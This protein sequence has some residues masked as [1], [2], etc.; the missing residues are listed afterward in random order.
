MV[1]EL[2]RTKRKKAGRGPHSSYGRLISHLDV[3]HQL[4]LINVIQGWVIAVD[5]RI[6]LFAWRWPRWTCLE[7]YSECTHPFVCIS[8]LRHNFIHLDDWKVRDFRCYIEQ[9]LG[10]REKSVAHTLN[11]GNIA[12]SLYKYPFPS[13]AFCKM[14]YTLFFADSKRYSMWNTRIKRPSG[15][16]SLSLKETLIWRFWQ[17][18]DWLLSIAVH[19]GPRFPPFSTLPLPG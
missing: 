5:V 15:G 7:V 6:R 1:C 12:I 9:A 19:I 4:R 16:I 13:C 11:R 8:T 18:L 17:E 10:I 14:V 3:Y 2:I